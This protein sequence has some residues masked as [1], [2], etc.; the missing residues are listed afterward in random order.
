MDIDDVIEQT[1]KCIRTLSKLEI[2]DKFCEVSLDRI[3]TEIKLESEKIV[4]Y[5][6]IEE[7]EENTLWKENIPFSLHTNMIQNSKLRTID[8]K[9]EKFSWY[10]YVRK[11]MRKIYHTFCPVHVMECKDFLRY[12]GEEFIR[13][14][15]ERILGR[16]VDKE[17]LELNKQ[18]LKNNKG[19]KY[20]ILYTVSHSEEAKPREIK[21]KGIWFSYYFY[22]L[23]N[24]LRRIPIIGYIL[25][26]IS[27]IIML[28]NRMTSI[29]NIVINLEEENENLKKK[30]TENMDA[31]HY[32]S[33]TIAIQINGLTRNLGN[34]ELQQRDI[35][36]N[37]YI[38][39]KEVFDNLSKD[40]EQVKEGFYPLL[41]SIQ[42]STIKDSLDN[43]SKDLEQV[44]EDF[45]P[46]LKSIQ[47]STIKDSLDNLSKDL[48]Q[49]KE[50]F[51]LLL[52][53]K[54]N[55][56]KERKDIKVL[57]DRFYLRYN[58]ELMSDSREKVQDQV[59][60]YIDILDKFFIK[61]KRK[62]LKVVDLGCGECEFVELLNQN[63]YC[64]IG[65]DDNQNV[66]KKVNQLMSNINIICERADKYLQEQA[67][68]SIDVI[69]SIH[70]IEHLGFE[71]ILLFLKECYRTL[72]SGGILIIETP[73][74]LNILIATYYFHLDP[75]H[76][77][78]IP[79]EL[80]HFYI[81]ETGFKV[82][83]EQML[84]PLNFIPYTYEKDDPIRDI[85]FR[86]N[87]EQAYS[88][89]AVKE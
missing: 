15:Y 8:S 54:R 71:E 3:I 80:L 47:E 23:K 48:E 22:R 9:L 74:P 52:E 73:N 35:K 86:F 72:K 55:K 5:K 32:L 18:H 21:I 33:D 85:I 2:E 49:V 37:L 88:I 87:M 63:G 62:E 75:T 24:K 42:E 53:E 79:K 34:I 7:E 16:E 12:D 13:N 11:I 1:N 56:E 77:A 67:D 59:K 20:C 82:M 14:V 26:I 61:E 50:D 4:E 78:P 76:V 81:E 45:Y 68:N 44:K 36:D 84:R 31:L 28:P 10:S 65:I 30:Y 38:L 46:L 17:A 39:E 19:F 58:E 6:R 69:S 57:K 43:L 70:M 29:Q 25:R 41:K 40:L 60:I 27:G 83:E 89:V 51:Y 64:A 66:I